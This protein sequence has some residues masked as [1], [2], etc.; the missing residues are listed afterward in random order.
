[1]LKRI[2]GQSLL[3]LSLIAFLVNLFFVNNKDI[4]HALSFSI[5]ITAVAGVI[6][7]IPSGVIFDNEEYTPNARVIDLVSKMR[8]RALMF[9]NLSVGI[10]FANLL[11]IIAGF[12]FLVNGAN[13]INSADKISGVNPTLDM[14]V[15][16]SVSALIIFLVQILFRV[17]KYLLRVAAFYNAK[18][19]AIELNKI[20]PEISLQELSEI[21]TP[22]SYDISDLPQPSIIDTVGDAIKGKTS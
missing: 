13:Q 17:F 11:V 21:L 2:L 5:I 18:A 15:R 1:M 4:R 6:L 3:G 8:F 9:N 14:T 22:D 10:F 19:D 16:I 20:K 7:I 12:Y